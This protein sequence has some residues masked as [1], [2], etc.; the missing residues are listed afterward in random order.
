M[1]AKTSQGYVASDWVN[2]LQRSSDKDSIVS[3]ETELIRELTPRFNL[4]NCGRRAR[5]TEEE[6]TEMQ[7]CRSIGLTY[8]E[9]GALFNVD[10]RTA[11][12]YIDGISKPIND[13]RI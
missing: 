6:V 8:L 11:K 4:F 1:D 7:A 13:L 2:I 3:Q 12:R 5:K 10:R 9:I